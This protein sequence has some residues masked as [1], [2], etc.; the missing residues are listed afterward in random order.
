MNKLG[1]ALLIAEIRYSLLKMLFVIQE[2]DTCEKEDLIED[3]KALLH[4][5]DSDQFPIE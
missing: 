1:I 2:D 3:I 5:I 4:V